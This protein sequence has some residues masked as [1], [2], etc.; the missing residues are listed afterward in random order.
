[1]IKNI[2]DLIIYIHQNQDSFDFSKINIKDKAV[3]FSL[4]SQIKRNLNFTENQAN[5]LVRILKDN[6]NMFLSIE[7]FDQLIDKPIFKNPFRIIDRTRHIDIVEL[8]GKKKISIRFPFDRRI[9]KLISSIIPTRL[10]Y[11]ASTKSYITKLDKNN[12]IEL[13]SNPDVAS[14]NFTIATE[15]KEIYKSIKEI[16]ENKGNYVPMI[17]YDGNYILKN[18]HRTVEN[19]FIKNKT[20][21]FLSNVFLANSLGLEYSENI[22]KKLLSGEFDR[23]ISKLLLKKSNK[24]YLSTREYDTSIIASVLDNLNQWPVLIVLV[25]NETVDKDLENWHTCFENFN[26]KSHEIS[27]L[28][29]SNTNKSIND[30]ISSQKLNNLVDKNTKVVF[31]KHKVPKILYKI[32]FS[33]KIIISSSTFYAHFTTQKLINS[34]PF[35]LF[36]TDQ[37]KANLTGIEVV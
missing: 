30:Y 33:P 34:H 6:R 9:S 22:T 29:R 36:H 31:I 1:M 20:D 32:N 26:I 21:N 28:F 37:T 3:V 5:L 19:Y 4:V 7:D 14:Y 10:E 17:D 27:V 16:E 12:I 25:D 23:S 11:Q 8:N 13:L 18:C 24:L 2:E 35:V 15:L